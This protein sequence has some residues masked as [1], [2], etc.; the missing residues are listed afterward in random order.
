[1]TAYIFPGQGTQSVGMGQEYFDEFKDLVIQADEVLG[2]SIKT[3]CLEDPDKKLNFTRYTQPALFTVNALAYLK[4][5]QETGKR[6]DIVA[7]HSLGEY[8]ALFAAGV[9]DFATGLKLVKKRGELMGQAK[10]GR[11]AAVMGMDEQAVRAVIKENRLDSIDIANLNVPVQTVISGKEEDVKNCIEIF[12]K[13]GARR[14]ILLNVSGAFHS[15]YMAEA[16]KEFAEYVEQ[17]SFNE[18]EITVLSNVYARPYRKEQLKE[19]MIKQITSSVRW[20]DIIR[21]IWGMDEQGEILQIGPGRV[22][23]DMTIKIKQTVTPLDVSR[24]QEEEAK[25]PEVTGADGICDIF[26]NNEFMKEYGLRYAYAAGP[27]EAGITTKEMVERCAEAGLLGIYATNTLPYEQITHDVKYLTD[28]LGSKYFGVAVSPDW[29]DSLR[30]E[31]IIDILCR[32]RVRMVQF[33]RYINV[34]NTIVRYKANGLS[35]EGRQE[36]GCEN[37]VMIKLSRPEVAAVFARPAP[38]EMI[39]ELLQVGEITDEQAERLRKMPIADDICVESNSAGRTDNASTLATFPAIAA[40]VAEISRQYHYHKRIRVGC[41]GSI[42]NPEAV[43]ALFTLGADFVMTG[44]INQC[45][46]EAGTSKLIKKVLQE[47]EIQDTEYIPAGDNYDY[48]TKIQVAKKGVLFAVRANKL[49]ETYKMYNSISELNP[50]LKEQIEENYFNKTFES[51]FDMIRPSL[52]EVQLRR[53][54]KLPKY[55]MALIFNWYYLQGM[56][57]AINGNESN[58]LNALIYCSVA[59][60]AFNS[61]VK[62]TEL[63]QWEN[64][65]IDVIGIKLMN[66]ARIIY[67]KKYEQLSG[68]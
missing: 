54:E 44:S 6:P 21:Y 7:G 23:T 38:E 16:Q 11:M 65:H 48:N 14:V 61:Y 52:S 64:R 37:K 59:M 68:R 20:I 12:E 36:S 66:D 24:L 41:A 34:S 15:R 35:S 40:M 22:L 18:P 56:A 46:V 1:M 26:G 39:R 5:L 13:A 58:M 42:G 10:N 31:A 28:R 67:Q 3:L 43:A 19:T 49:Y 2:Y 4:R 60:G 57:D 53:L 62:N 51:V 33:S 8:N 47:I 32:H 45:T 27:M 55:K 9:F 29:S 30:E 25:I 17:F 63:E 50:E